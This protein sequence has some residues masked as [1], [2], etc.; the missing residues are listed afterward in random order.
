MMVRP[1]WPS[2]FWL[3]KGDPFELNHTAN[4]EI[5][6]S[7]DEAMRSIAEN[8]KSRARLNRSYFAWGVLT[9]AS[10][11]V[12]SARISSFVGAIMAGA[13]DQGS[14]GAASFVALGVV[15]TTVAD[16]PAACPGE[17]NAAL[18]I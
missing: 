5:T 16:P 3:Y 7:G 8:V 13:S 10:S 2:L 1:R 12:N 15:A 9:A 11:H 4:M 6:I 18:S 14:S 17:E